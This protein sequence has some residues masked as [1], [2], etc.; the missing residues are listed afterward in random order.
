MVWYETVLVWI[1]IIGS[2]A[3]FFP[4][5]RDWV[6]MKAKEFCKKEDRVDS[7]SDSKVIVK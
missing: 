1:I 7:N 5:E 2:L 3:I 6:I 4:K